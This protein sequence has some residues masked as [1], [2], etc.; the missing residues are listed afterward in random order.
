[1]QQSSLVGNL[2]KSP[3][4]KNLLFNYH[5]KGLQQYLG[6]CKHDIELGDI[7]IESFSNIAFRWL[8][9]AFIVKQQT[10]NAPL[11]ET[12]DDM[13]ILTGAE[14]DLSDSLSIR[15]RKATQPK[16]NQTKTKGRSN[17][18]SKASPSP[19]NPNSP[20]KS[21]SKPPLKDPYKASNKI[22]ESALND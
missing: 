8:D 5:K 18:N 6:F 7:V 11:A 15:V 19:T 12:L 10:L 16:V 13:K 21:L 1:M 3:A 14:S 17:T 22:C 2:R 20:L 9:L 4:R